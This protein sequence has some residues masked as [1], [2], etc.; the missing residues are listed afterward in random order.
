MATVRDLIFDYL[1]VDAVL[2]GLG[3]TEQSM[4]NSNDADTPN[5]RPFMVFRWGATSAGMDVMRRRTLQVW[6]HD[7][8]SDYTRIDTGLERVRN[9]LTML[10]GVNVDA[11]TKW[12]AQ[13][14]WTSDSDDLFDD[15]Q[16]TIARYTQFDVI[17]SAS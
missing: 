7:E 17:G 6:L 1:K 13:I 16:N 14:D 15:V 11:T 2:N 4:F 8:P 9:A 10:V 3:F 5:M 12:V